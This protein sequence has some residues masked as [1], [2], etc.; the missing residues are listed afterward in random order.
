MCFVFFFLMIRRP[1]RSTLFPYTTL[2]RSRDRRA[3]A[4]HVAGRRRPVS[5]RVAEDVWRRESPHVLGA[6]L[7]RHGD[8]GDCEDAAQEAAEAAARQ[9]ETDGVPDNPRGWLIRVAS[10]RLIDRLRTDRARAGREEAV[11]V[12]QPG[13]AYVV[14]PADQAHR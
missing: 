9:W 12:A 4:R 1:P 6:L 3:A 2:F 5:T 14:A 10:R 11:A 13:D 7:R 8:L